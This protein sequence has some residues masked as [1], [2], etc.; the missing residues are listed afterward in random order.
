M[1]EPSSE[2][3]SPNRFLAVSRIRVP[4][5]FDMREFLK[6]TSN[7]QGQ[8]RRSEGNLYAKAEKDPESQ[9]TFWSTSLWENE[10]VEKEFATSRGAHSDARRHS[11]DSGFEVYTA[12][13][14]WSQKSTPSLKD[15]REFLDKKEQ[16]ELTKQ[17][18][19]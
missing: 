1:I 7:S 18:S 10:T 19:T 15:A 14:I 17:S 8:A 16:E 13:G 9:N 5:G 6:H 3:L 2:A 4:E 12:T 11:Q